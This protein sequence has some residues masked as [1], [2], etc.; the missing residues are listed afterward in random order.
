MKR[1]LFIKVTKQYDNSGRI[2]NKILSNNYNNFT[3]YEIFESFV[4]NRMIIKNQIKK[5]SMTSG[6]I[7]GLKDYFS[8][9]RNFFIS[10]F[11]L[12]INLN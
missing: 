5:H 7:L 10:K 1:D 4:E 9:P 8:L 12:P 6:K 2:I 11:N 3:R